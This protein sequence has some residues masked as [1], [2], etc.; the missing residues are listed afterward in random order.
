MK[1]PIYTDEQ[2]AM[3]EKMGL[4]DQ[5]KKGFK[6]VSNDWVKKQKDT[7]SVVSAL[8]RVPK[9]TLVDMYIELL[10]EVHQLRD[11]LAEEPK[12]LLDCQAGKLTSFDAIVG[13]VSRL[14][15]KIQDMEGEGPT[16]GT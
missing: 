6:M 11:E 7:P 9:K 14:E 10:D 4:F 15:L 12:L 13:Y 3:Y 8:S 5:C 16:I 2:V 1:H